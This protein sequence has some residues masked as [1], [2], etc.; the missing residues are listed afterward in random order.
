MLRKI[1]ILSGTANMPLALEVCKNLS[2]PLT[3]AKVNRHPDGEVNVQLLEAVRDEDVFIINPTNPPAEN[4]LELIFLCDAARRS[5]AGRIT[6]VIPY[7]GY[8][9]QDRKDKPRVPISSWVIAQLL[10]VA[11]PNR[12]LLIDPHS[13]PTMASFDKVVVDHFYASPVCIDYFRPK[14]SDVFVVASPDSGGV[15]R[16]KTFAKLLGGRPYVIFDKTRDS[17]GKVIPGKIQIIGDVKDKDVLFVDDIIDT[18]GTLM[19][20]VEAA[21]NAG[22]RKIFAFMTHGTLSGSATLRIQGSRI[23]EVVLTDTIHHDPAKLEVSDKIKI[24]SI[25]QMLARAIMSIH[26]GDSVSKLIPT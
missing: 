23:D 11:G 2:V 14:V 19:E 3:P 8:D 24:I 1:K 22:A 6:L 16:A 25:S 13:E 9:R 17:E 10:Q 4:F 20:D 15:T 18:A 5:S 7:W 12:V 26:T 21:V